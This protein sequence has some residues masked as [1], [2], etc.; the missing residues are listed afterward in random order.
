MH[1]SLVFDLVDA[2][3][4]TLTA[5]FFT[6]G[7]SHGWDSSADGED[8]VDV[9]VGTAFF[10][11][12]FVLGV[13]AATTIL[14]VFSVVAPYYIGE[15][16]FGR[17]HSTLG[18]MVGVGLNVADYLAYVYFPLIIVA[19]STLTGV[20]TGYYAQYYVYGLVSRITGRG[21]EDRR[22]VVRMTG[23]GKI[24]VSQS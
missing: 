18:Y 19:S 23:D 4:V 16:F 17:A 24:V 2:A 8:L 5:L 10:A 3:Y 21:G 12:I 7:F 11:A 6:I 9:V 20:A 15:A 14:G 22:Y 13:A 1:P